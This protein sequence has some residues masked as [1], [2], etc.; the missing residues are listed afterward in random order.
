MS[1]QED[2]INKAYYNIPKEIGINVGWELTPIWRGF[3][4][5]WHKLIRKIIR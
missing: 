2:A 5:Y 4:F 3:K 1:K